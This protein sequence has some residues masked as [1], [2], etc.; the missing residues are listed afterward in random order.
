MYFLA[1]D[2][3]IPLA[4]EEIWFVSELTVIL[5]LQLLV[6]YRSFLRL[7]LCLNRC[8]MRWCNLYWCRNKLT[9]VWII[10]LDPLVVVRSGIYTWQCALWII[11]RLISLWVLVSPDGFFFWAPPRWYSTEK[12]SGK[13]RSSTEHPLILCS[14]VV[15]IRSG[16]Q[17]Y[18]LSCS[19]E[20][21]GQ[22]AVP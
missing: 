12:W 13:L 7:F 22:G 3:D 6:L 20:S 5:T 14:W 11:C 21:V 8:M 2:S 10:K 18:S 4:H 17:Y 15:N 19:I 1:L 9:V 16:V